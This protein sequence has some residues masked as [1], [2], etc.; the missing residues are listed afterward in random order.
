ML[1]RPVYFLEYN[2]STHLLDRY[3]D[4]AFACDSAW[5]NQRVTVSLFRLQ[6]AP[7]K[8]ALPQNHNQSNICQQHLS[9]EIRQFLGYHYKLNPFHAS[10]LV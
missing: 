6:M 10:L 7:Y 5:A 8:N 3:L 9:L 1:S 4:Q 2:F